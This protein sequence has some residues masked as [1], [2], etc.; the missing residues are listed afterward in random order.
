MQ[1]VCEHRLLSVFLLYSDVTLQM[2]NL[3]DYIRGKSW[4]QSFHYSLKDKLG[5]GDHE[6][7]VIILR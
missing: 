5:E 3:P 7:T 6:D 4:F 1:W 2:A